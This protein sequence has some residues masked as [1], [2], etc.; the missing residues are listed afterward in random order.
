MQIQAF[1]AKQAKSQLSLFQ[2]SEPELGPFDLLLEI[3]HCG[4]C[5]SDIHLIDNDWNR[6]TYPLVP[7]HEVVGIVRKKGPSAEYNIGD[8][9][10]VSWLY[11]SCLSCSTCLEGNNQLC[12]QKKTTCL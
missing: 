5:H 3:T 6:S 2:Y 1:A 4:L 9:V 11:S 12:P 7:G 8:R 10:G